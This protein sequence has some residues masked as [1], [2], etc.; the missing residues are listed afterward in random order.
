VRLEHLDV[1]VDLGECNVDHGISF[2]VLSPFLESILSLPAQLQNK[3]NPRP[4][5]LG[6]SCPAS[7]LPTVEMGLGLVL[8]FDTCT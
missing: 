8:R 2:F 3:P 6:Y 7:T 4:M 1:G 5:Q